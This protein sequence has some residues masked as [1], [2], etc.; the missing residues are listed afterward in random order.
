MIRHRGY[1][2]MDRDPRAAALD[3]TVR[4]FGEAWA[5]GDGAALDALLSPTY[6]HTDAGGAFLD[7]AAWL[8]YAQKRAGRTTRIAFR[9]LRTRFV[10]DAA[11]VTGINE[12]EGAGVRSATDT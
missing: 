4:R 3:E 6:T 5:R 12:V 10:G 1:V 8:A 9:D 11:I 7:R 2:S